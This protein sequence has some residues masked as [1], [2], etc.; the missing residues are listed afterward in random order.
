MIDVFLILFILVWVVLALGVNVKLLFYYMQSEDRQL[1]KSIYVK[2]VVVLTLSLAWLMVM[3][4]PL[5]VRNAQAA[6][7]DTMLDMGAFWITLFILTA[8]SLIFIIPGT[9]FYYEVEDDDSVKSKWITVAWQWGACVIITCLI[10]I[11]FF[12]TCNGAQIPV[13][14]YSCPLGTSCIESPNPQASFNAIVVS[15]EI[16]IVGLLCFIGWLVF[17]TFGGIGLTALP[18]C[19]I[20]SFVDRPIPIDLSLYAEKKRTYGDTANA[21]LEEAEK[22]SQRDTALKEESGWAASQKKRKLRNDFNKFK[23]TAYLLEMEYEKIEVAMKLR[24]ENPLISYANLLLG[25]I[26]AIVSFVWWLHIIIFVLADASP[27]LNDFLGA[28]QGAEPGTNSGTFIIAMIVY[29]FLN[30]HLLLC[31]IHGCVKVG[32]KAFCL[33][34]HPMRPQNT[35]LNSFLFNCVI[36]Q[37]ASCAITQ[38][39]QNALK[40]Y[41]RSSSAAN[42]FQAQIRY[43]TFFKFFNDNNVFSWLLIFWAVLS[44]IFLLIKPRDS[45]ALNLD[46]K[47]ENAFKKAVAGA[48]KGAAKAALGLS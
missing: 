1:T 27:F 11:I 25:I 3:L 17:V 33:P 23:Q 29:S 38:F 18:M 10:V 21:L 45:P 43:L 8:V 15:F 31:V 47:A 22:L 19:Y 35:P 37:L 36:I 4:L 16:F 24:G 48:K 42:I 26:F 28:I 46:G 20:F 6:R 14:E 12:F 39:S 7:G 9:I 40:E 2:T 30:I 44:V 34:I 32:M 13:T 5:D 41:S